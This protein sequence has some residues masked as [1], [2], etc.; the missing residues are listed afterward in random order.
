MVDSSNHVAIAHARRWSVIDS[1]DRLTPATAQM[2]YFLYNFGESGSPDIVKVR[3][4]WT[5]EDIR[6]PD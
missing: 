6:R 5:N 1:N 4:L 2:F 3:Q